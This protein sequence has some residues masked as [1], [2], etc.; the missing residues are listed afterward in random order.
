MN[1]VRAIYPREERHYNDDKKGNCTEDRGNVTVSRAILGSTPPRYSAGATHPGVR[2]GSPDAN[3]FRVDV[4]CDL[5]GVSC[6][7]RGVGRLST[8]MILY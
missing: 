1:L 3:R 6:D 8:R 4:S 7:L 5:R 2:C